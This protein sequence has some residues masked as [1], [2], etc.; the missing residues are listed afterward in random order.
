MNIFLTS[1][2]C[3][4]LEKILP[5]LPK[6]AG[7][8]T[9]AF[10]RTAA[11]PYPEKPWIDN[12]RKKLAEL[13][14][15]IVDLDIAGKSEAEVQKVLSRVDI[16][17]VAGGNTFY[18]LEQA[19]KSGFDKI[20]KD[21][22]NSGK[23]YIGSSAGSI[24]LGPEIKMFDIID[25]PGKAQLHDT[26]ALGVVDFIVLPHLGNE[27]YRDRQQ[28]VLKKYS[29]D[30]DIIPFTDRQFIKADGDKYDVIAV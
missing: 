20:V 8:L 25:D 12:D 13:G 21:F 19:R 5:E 29:D 10:I 14:F 22:I 1:K 24:L 16:I 27:K 28:E 3:M 15:H 17:F 11:N 23:I 26:K 18:L 7:E 30:Y 6:P 9:V 4:V 2:A